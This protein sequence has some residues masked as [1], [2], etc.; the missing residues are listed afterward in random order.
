MEVVPQYGEF[1]EPQPEPAARHFE[2]RRDRVETAPAAEVPDMAR[3]PQGH[4]HGR[5]LLE[6]RSALVRHQGLWTLRRA[7]GAAALSS[8]SREP[9]LEL[10]RPAHD[11]GQIA[12]FI[13]VATSVSRPTAWEFRAYGSRL[14]RKTIRLIG[15]RLLRPSP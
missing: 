3:D 6:P 15:D 12:G 5:C 4:V 8:A 13:S 2:A 1:D 7:A 14:H 11:W 10:F 9:E